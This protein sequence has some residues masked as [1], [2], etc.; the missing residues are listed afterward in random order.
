[1]KDINTLEELA[2]K[3]TTK[4]LAMEFLIFQGQMTQTFDKLLSHQEKLT[5]QITKLTLEVTAQKPEVTRFKAFINTIFG[6]AIAI[7]VS[8]IMFYFTKAVKKDPVLSKRG[9]T[10][11]VIEIEAEPLTK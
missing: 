4:K 8:V 6:A 1:M 11:V 7:I 3:Y 2:K 9:N 5:E 10:E